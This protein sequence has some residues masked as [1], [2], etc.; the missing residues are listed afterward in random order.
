M[1]LL[2]EEAVQRKQKAASDGFWLVWNILIPTGSQV[3]L[4][5]PH[6][7]ARWCVLVFQLVR[8]PDPPQKAQT[9]GPLTTLSLSK[10]TR[11]RK[12]W[13]WLCFCCAATLSWLRRK[14]DFFT[15][16]I[17]VSTEALARPAGLFLQPSLSLPL[18]L[19]D[20]LC[21]SLRLSA[22][23]KH[24]QGNAH[25]YKSPRLRASVSADWHCRLSAAAH[26]GC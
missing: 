19:P 14:H 2:E 10:H 16:L 21:V 17:A 22:C 6:L 20:Y 12:E 18:H 1:C 4:L 25:L 13:L 8:C 5:N 23:R 24:H 11:H 7:A 3:S 9:A 26:T 15:F